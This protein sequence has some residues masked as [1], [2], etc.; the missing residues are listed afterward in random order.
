MVGQ[1]AA[2]AEVVRVG[3]Q[4]LAAVNVLRGA[5]LA[6][7]EREALEVETMRWPVFN[8]EVVHVLHCRRA[9]SVLRLEGLAAAVAPLPGSVRLPHLHVGREDS[10]AYALLAGWHPAPFSRA[11]GRSRVDKWRVRDAGGGWTVRLRALAAAGG[12]GV[13]D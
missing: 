2:A 3:R 8:E 9:A 6:C 13:L 11:L 10:R 12:G 7:A 1:V 4:I 5:A